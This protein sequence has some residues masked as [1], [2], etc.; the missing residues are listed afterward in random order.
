MSVKID[1]SQLVQW[2][3]HLLKME[4]EIPLFTEY[5]TK[6]LAQRLLAMTIKLTPVGDYKKDNI[7]QTYKR[8]N[9]N[10]GTKAGDVILSKNGKARLSNMKEISFTTAKGK[11]VSFKAV[12][13]KMGGTL[14]RGW[15]AKAQKE[16]MG[17]PGTPQAG[18]IQ[19]YLNSLYVV[20]SGNRCH[21][22]IINP[23]EYASFVEFGHRT[24]GGK[25]F[26]SGRFMLTKSEKEL[27]GKL[28]TI[29]EPMLTQ[30]MIKMFEY[31][32]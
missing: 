21:I 5:C 7:K 23:V 12:N 26:V 9:K 29:L 16:A 20:R 11:Q 19:N 3:D 13:N 14:R 22:T 25:G 6:Q 31:K 8:N 2:R 1:I 27:Q 32:K 30:F 24:R 15:T 4:K 28:Q 10:K 17:N 18:D